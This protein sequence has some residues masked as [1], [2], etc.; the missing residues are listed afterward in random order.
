MYLWRG[1]RNCWGGC[2]GRRPK[3]RPHHCSSEVM[4]HRRSLEHLLTRTS[5]VLL[6]L[7]KVRHDSHQPALPCGPP[8]SILTPIFALHNSKLP[9]PNSTAANNRIHQRLNHTH[10][11]PSSPAPPLQPS[12]Q[13]TSSP[14]SPSA[15]TAI[16]PPTLRTPLLPRAA[17]PPRQMLHPHLLPRLHLTSP[18][19]PPISAAPAAPPTY[20]SPR[21]SS[22]KASPAA[23]A[24]PTSSPPSPPRTPVPIM[25]PPPTSLTSQTHIFTNPCRANSSRARTR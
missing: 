11:C 22:P 13:S 4:H 7:I 9:P 10:Q 14:P 5:H 24:A 2:P 8:Y 1:R 3:C 18:A 12:S 6:N 19:T 25:A 16:P 15:A 21:R 23:T 20:A 17:P